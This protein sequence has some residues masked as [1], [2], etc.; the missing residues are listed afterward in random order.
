[1]RGLLSLVDRTIIKEI[2]VGVVAVD[3]H[4]FRDI[5]SP[6]PALELDHDVK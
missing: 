5:A 3:F 6:G 2:G 4:D 1:M